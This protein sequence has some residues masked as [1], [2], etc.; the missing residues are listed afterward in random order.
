MC[1]KDPLSVKALIKSFERKVINQIKY[2]ILLYYKNY[3]AGTF[4]LHM[5]F[6]DFPSESAC[7]S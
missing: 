6:R 4:E 2:I 3:Q 7:M 5:L 1:K